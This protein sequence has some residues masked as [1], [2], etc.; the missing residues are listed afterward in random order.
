M[1]TLPEVHNQTLEPQ[2]QRS[3]DFRLNPEELSAFTQN[4]FVVSER[5][6]AQ[7]FAEMFYRIY[8]NDLPVFVSTDSILYAWH[9]SYDKALQELEITYLA[10]SLAQLLE[11]MAAEIPS[12]WE[13]HSDSALA[14]GIVDADYFLAVARSL[15]SGNLVKPYLSQ[16][17]R[18]TETLT[19]IKRQQAQTFNPGCLTHLYEIQTHQ[20]RQYNER[21]REN[22][23]SS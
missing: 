22:Q 13:Q 17:T 4:S 5:L 23:I 15:L 3:Y 1:F 18:V 9:L 8:T 7:S 6:G 20:V 11:N 21:M 10:P 16:E 12:L 19:A 14:S 2:N